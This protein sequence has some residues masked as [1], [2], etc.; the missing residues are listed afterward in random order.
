MGAYDLAVVSWDGNSLQTND[1]VAYLDDEANPLGSYRGDV[2]ELEQVDAHPEAVGRSYQ[3][4]AYALVITLKDTTQSKLTA[5]KRL[6]RPSQGEKY[7]RVT[8]GADTPLTWRLLC[9]CQEFRRLPDNPVV[10]VAH[11][12]ASKPVWEQDSETTDEQTDK[13]SSPV[14][15]AVTNA[16][17]DLTYP[18]FT[19]TPTVSK[20]HANG[21]KRRWRVIIANKVPR[22]IVDTLG[23]A[24]PIDIV[25]NGLDTATETTANLQADGDDLRVIVDGR[26]IKGHVGVDRWLQDMDSATTQVWCNIAFQPGKS[27]TIKSA[28]TVDSPAS[29]ESI[30]VS[31]PDGLGDWPESGFLVFTENGQ[32]ECIHY[33][34][35]TNSSFHDITRAVWATSATAH[36]AGDVCYWVEHDI[37]I[38]FDY[39]AAASPP[40][41]DD[42]KPVISLA[43]TNAAFTWPGPFF[44]LDTRRSGQ[45]RPLYR[46]ENELSP[47]M[48]IQDTGEAVKFIDS[49]AAAGS[50]KATGMEQYVPYGVA[51]AAGALT[52]DVVVP[53]NMLLR[54]YGTDE[55]G[56]EALLAEWNPDTDGDSEAVT[57]SDELIRVRYAALHRTITGA[58]PDC[59]DFGLTSDALLNGALNDS[60]TTIPYDGGTISNS[61]HFIRI[62]SEIVFYTA[63]A[64]GNL[65][66]C[67]RG[68]LGTTAAAHDDD[69][70]IYEIY[71]PAGEIDTIGVQCP[72]GQAFRLDQDTLFKGVTL[73]L[74]RTSTVDG[75]LAI[76]IKSLSGTTEGDQMCGFVIDSATLAM[77]TTDWTDI[78]ALLPATVKLPAG[79]YLLLLYRS[80]TTGCL[81]WAGGTRVY[82]P[83]AWLNYVGTTTWAAQA[84][85]SH[86]FRVL[87]DGSVCQDDA[88]YDT[89]E[90]C[91]LDD[92]IITHDTPP[93]VLVCAKEEIYSY[94]ATLENTTTGEGCDI[95]FISPLTE[96]LTINCETGE[97]TDALGLPV[98]WA[99]TFWDPVKR[100][101]L[102]PGS[103]T[104]K[105]TETG[106]GTLTIGTA[107][108]GRAQ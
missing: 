64:G 28:M 30:E 75:Y 1:Y 89:D 54:A 27:A 72:C 100:I 99:V 67:V 19:I 21:Y 98:P 42:T 94:D 7:L 88:P 106:I 56:N 96:E 33:G 60:A 12:W 11:L 39:T 13:S 78:V 10:W 87:G 52:Q 22:A 2:R 16:G 80:S 86:W 25:N 92:I 66:G 26:G 57:P 69:S 76:V 63:A 79:D 102:A 101:S 50:P 15:W 108:R 93:F 9:Y 37:Q 74:F 85:F 40:A 6:F 71:T 105:Y 103:N 44:D 35:R 83:G 20:D 70:L 49:P 65:T 29:G 97:V 51:A 62:D 58:D 8:D 36:D 4:K 84:Q 34:S 23:A 55:E 3:G 41:P 14:E 90:Y 68:A 38:E 32:Q 91:Q 82:A 48:S 47:V 31:N 59:T 5:L 24:Y 46:E 17:D 73:R 43:S 77:V 107:H 95:H 81:M 61:P 104:L 45:W 18:T 53:N